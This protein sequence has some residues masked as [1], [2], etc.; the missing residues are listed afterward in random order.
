LQPP[1]EF[2]CDACPAARQ[3]AA[4][5]EFEFVSQQSLDYFGLTLD[6]LKGYE[7]KGRTPSDIVHPDDLSRMLATWRRSVETG[8][9]YESEYRIRRADDVYRWFNVR[10]LPWRNTEGHIIR[11]YTLRTDIDDR[12]RIEEA[13]RASK[14]NLSLVVDSI[15]GL[16]NTMTAEGENEFV[17]QQVLAYFGKSPEELNSWATSDLIHPDDLPRVIAAF[18]SSIE[19]GQPYDIEHRIR[20]ADGIPRCTVSAL[21]EGGSEIWW[22]H[23]DSNLE[24]KRYEHSALTD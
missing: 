12:K 23:Q 4:D 5:G 9:P 21:G 14:F 3:S 7:S 15:P 2:D 6:E 17:N 13:L 16:V 10:S 8:H 11:W 22:A 24:P 19:T 20:R 1:T 18:T